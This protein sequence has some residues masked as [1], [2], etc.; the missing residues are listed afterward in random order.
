ME[1]RRK[2]PRIEKIR[3]DTLRVPPAGTAQR[4]FREAKGDRI[5]A[6][7]DINSFG[8]PAVCRVDGIPSARRWAAPGLRHPEMRLREGERPDRV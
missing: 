5:A 1:S 6:E 7:F 3:L 4:P 8:F 2:P